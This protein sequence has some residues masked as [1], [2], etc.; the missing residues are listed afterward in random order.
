MEKANVV[1]PQALGKI[2][3]THAQAEE[4]RRVLEDSERPAHAGQEMPAADASILKSRQSP[5]P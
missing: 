3:L 4:I 2:R 5:S 1:L